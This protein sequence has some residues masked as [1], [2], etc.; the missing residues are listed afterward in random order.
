MAINA[1]NLM[2]RQQAFASVQT[3]ESY[4][5]MVRGTVEDLD[6]GELSPAQAKQILDTAHTSPWSAREKAKLQELI[7]MVGQDTEAALIFARANWSEDLPTHNNNAGEAG[8]G[9]T[10]SEPYLARAV[11]GEESGVAATATG[12]P[13]AVVSV[14]QIETAMLVHHPMLERVTMAATLA[15]NLVARAKRGGKNAAKWK[16]DATVQLD[17]FAAL[18][19]DVAAH[20]IHE[21]LKVVDAGDGTWLVA[22]GRHRLAAAQQAGLATVPCIAVAEADVPNIIESA[23][24]TRRHMT[25]SAIA[26]LGVLLHPEVATEASSRSAS[27]VNARYSTTRTECGSY[28]VATEA[29]R[30]NPNFPNSAQNAELEKIGEDSGPAQNA[31]PEEKGQETMEALGVRLGVGLR[32]IEQACELYRL[33]AV[34]PA[35]RQQAEDAIWSGDG[36]GGVIA[37]IKSPEQADKST[38]EKNRYYQQVLKAI[39]G[40]SGSFGAWDHVPEDSRSKLIGQLQEAVA[41]APEAIRAAI[42]DALQ[43]THIKQ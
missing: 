37:G 12:E 25:K 36:L 1:F 29:K 3:R 16:E 34:R 2:Q 5:D 20:G 19:A 18:V 26:Y 32:L 31:G 13:V 4:R 8:S 39:C 30:G 17:T 23:V 6:A 43:A 38:G 10:Q 28:E 40:F 22:D 41:E 27:N 9:E 15:G 42:A 11:K 21:P 14:Q 35:I 24:A 33:L 7:E